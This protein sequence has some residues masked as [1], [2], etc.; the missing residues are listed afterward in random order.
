M[1]IFLDTSLGGRYLPNHKQRGDAADLR[2]NEMLFKDMTDA[3]LVEAYWAER[4]LCSLADRMA[5]APC[6]GTA[7]KRKQAGNVLR[8]LKNIDI[9]VAIARK[10][11]V[12]LARTAA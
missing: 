10:R 3:G 1:H 2:E 4:G 11:G 9:I 8:H 5:S 6:A 7:M 12:N